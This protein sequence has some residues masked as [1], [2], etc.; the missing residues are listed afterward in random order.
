MPQK[1]QVKRG[2][3]AK[4]QSYTL[5]DGELGWATD[6]KE[7]FIGT[8][9]TNIPIN[10][11]VYNTE[12]EVQSAFP[13]GTDMPVWVKSTK[14]WYFWDDGTTPSDITPPTVVVNVLGGTYTSVQNVNLST[15]AGA[16]I[17]YTLDGSTPTQT[18]SVYTAALVISSS[19]VLKYFAKDSAGN[20]SDVQTQTYTINM[21]T[22]APTVTVYPT[23]GAYTSSQSVTF[24]TNETATIYY[25]KDGSTPTT[26]SSVYTSA[27]VL[28]ATGTIKYFAKDV[29]GNSSGIQTATYTINIP[30]ATPPSSVQGLK[31]AAATQN[32]ITVSWNANTEPD[33]AGYEVSISEVV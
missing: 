9:L 29:A 15:E 27:I 33:L 31:V 1:I 28:N 8:G 4:L 16:I 12:A 10:P 26:G 25:T 19:K 11:L 13:S 5:S 2:A 24:T 20:V 21:D 32:S 22:T 3:K 6:T 23:P 18:S 7:L 17:Y 30:D 14:R